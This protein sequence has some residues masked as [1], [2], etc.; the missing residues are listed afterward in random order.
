MSNVTHGP[1]KK[2]PSLAFPFKEKYVTKLI[3][4]ICAIK[5]IFSFHKVS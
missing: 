5:S 2:V 4:N 1:Q 3:T